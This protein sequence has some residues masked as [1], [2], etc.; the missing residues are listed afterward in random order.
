MEEN[1]FCDTEKEIEE[2]R[3]LERISEIPIPSWKWF[4][5][6]KLSKLFNIKINLEYPFHYK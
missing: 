4:I 6:C 2:N 1:I 5:L 3:E